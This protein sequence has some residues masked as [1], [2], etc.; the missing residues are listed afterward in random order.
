MTIFNSIISNLSTII[1]SIASI[2]N[3]FLNAL[4]SFLSLS[5]NFS[6]NATQFLAVP[7]NRFDLRAAVIIIFILGNNGFFVINEEILVVFC[8]LIALLIIFVN[9][10][11][12]TISSLDERAEG[13]RK[14]LSVFL[15]LKQEN[16]GD[17]YKT[18]ESF[19]N[20]TE[21]IRVLQ[22][23]TRE[24]FALLGESQQKTLVGLVAKN[25]QTQLIG[26]RSIKDSLQPLLHKQIHASFRTAVLEKLKQKA[27]GQS[28][29]DSLRKLKKLNNN[30]K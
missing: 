15:L 3:L 13:I 6:K 29:V 30:K 14:E 4:S 19:L 18:E 22:K 20:T 25:L 16:L 17:L 2:L 10:R 5:Y 12:T 9:V 1:N 27:K 23:Y 21:N 11:E 28:I 24:H 26:L 8:F 7:E